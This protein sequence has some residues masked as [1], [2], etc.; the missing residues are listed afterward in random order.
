[1]TIHSFTIDHTIHRLFSHFT[2]ATRVTSI[3]MSVKFQ[4]KFIFVVDLHV[5]SPWNFHFP[6]KISE[7]LLDVHFFWERILKCEMWMWFFVVRFFFLVCLKCTQWNQIKTRQCV[8]N[9]GQNVKRRKV[10]IMAMGRKNKLILILDGLPL[11]DGI[12]Q[13]NTLLLYYLEVKIDAYQRGKH[14]IRSTMRVHWLVFLRSYSK[15]VGDCHGNEVD[16]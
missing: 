11:T 13:N 16:F 2:F 8:M 5:V 7:L 14:S 6:P 9:C 12:S 1:M 15:K 3:S 4:L 10:Q